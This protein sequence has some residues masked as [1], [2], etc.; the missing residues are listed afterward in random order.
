MA[1]VESNEAVARLL[2]EGD[3]AILLT[4]LECPVGITAAVLNSKEEGC[5]SVLGDDRRYEY[6]RI[7]LSEEH[8]AT[9]DRDGFHAM[10][11]ARSS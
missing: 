7:D 6:S 8:V 4:V 10:F 2:P 1:T 5:S 3:Q 9:R 11:Q